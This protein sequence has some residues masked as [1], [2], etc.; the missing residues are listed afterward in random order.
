MMNSK[1]LEGLIIEATRITS[2]A[3]NVTNP[4]RYALGVLSKLIT[5]EARTPPTFTMAGVAEPIDPQECSH[6]WAILDETSDG[7]REAECAACHLEQ[8]FPL[9]RLLT[10]GEIERQQPS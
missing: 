3:E 5:E 7:S 8:T 6:R 9:G 2:Q 10:L 1:T 4:N